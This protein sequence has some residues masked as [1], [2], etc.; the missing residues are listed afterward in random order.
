MKTKTMVDWSISVAQANEVVMVFPSTDY[1]WDVDG[2]TGDDLYNTNKGF[3]AVFIN[4]I[5]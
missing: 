2:D 3:Q 5:I 4:K 1:C